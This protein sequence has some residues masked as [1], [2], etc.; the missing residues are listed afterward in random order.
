M[1][2]FVLRKCLSAASGA[3]HMEGSAAAGADGLVLMNGAQAVG[4]KKTEWTAALAQST[5][6]RVP[7]DK[8]AAKK[9][10]LLVAGHRYPSCFAPH[11]PQKRV[12]GVNATPHLRHFNAPSFAPHS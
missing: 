10:G 4:A 11:S 5:K 7:V 2:A 9:A 8:R 6:P 3:G 12:P 1:L